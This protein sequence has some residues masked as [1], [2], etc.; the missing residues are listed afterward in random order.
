MQLEVF[1]EAA[2]NISV[3]HLK[4]TIHFIRFIYIYIGIGYKVEH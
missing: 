2:K 1:C 3:M 4:S